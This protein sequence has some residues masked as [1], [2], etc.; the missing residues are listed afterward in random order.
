MGTTGRLVTIKRSGVDGTV[1][2][3]TLRTCLFGRGIECDIRIQLPVVSKQH[4]KIETNDQEAILYNFSSTNPTQVNG[5]AIDGPVPLRHGD[6]IT[7]IDRSFRYE[8]ESHQSESKSPEFPGKICEQTHEDE[9][10]CDTDRGEA[11]TLGAKEGVEAVDKTVTPRKLLTRNQT[12]TKCDDSANSGS[13]SG[14]SSSRK[15]RSNSTDVEVLPTEIQNQP[16]LTQC[17]AQVERKFQKDS[18]NTP[19]KFGATLGHTCSGF[20]GLSSV[21]ISNFGDSINKS[22]DISLKRRRVSFGGRLRPELFDEN[23]PPNTPL[24]RGETPAKRKS[25]GTHTPAV[26]KKIIKEQPQ[27]PRKEESSEICLEGKAQNVYVGTLAPGPRVT[28]PPPETDSQRRRSGKAF[29][30]S[31]SGK[32]PHQTDVPKKAGRKSGHLPSSKRSSISR[33]QQDILQMICSKRRSG[34]SEANLIV[35]KSWADVVKLGVKQTQTKAVKR[36]PQTQRQNKRQRRPSTP[37][38]PTSSIHN[39]FSTGHANSPC[40]IVIG[41]AQIE[42]VNVPARPYRML[43]NFV[44]NPKM[45]YNEDL[46]GLTEMFKTPV[47]KSQMKSSYSVTPSNSENLLEKKFQVTNS[48]EKSQGIWFHLHIFWHC[49]TF[50]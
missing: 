26:L 42:K 43:N 12:P 38:K 10:L 6:I 50:E 48:G 28:S 39:Q 34:A 46:S 31:D 40:T 1:F 44:F 4:C 49:Y 7:I 23:L 47:K 15:R 33:S 14:N 32:S 13:K 20:P 45:D 24:K 2:P 41:K 35:A 8:N 17:L 18:L 21:D 22:E 11:A 25:L 37:K 36:G 27:L 30:A 19:E 5:C 29:T 3:L 16:L 9:D